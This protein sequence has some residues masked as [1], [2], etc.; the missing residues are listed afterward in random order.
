MKTHHTPGYWTQSKI[1]PTCVD[2]ATHCIVE[3]RVIDDDTD[4]AIAN[5]CLIAAAPNLLEALKSCLEALRGSAGP[6]EINNARAAAQLAI[7]N[8]LVEK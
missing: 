6:D 3:C 2:S 1:I 4:T 8:A 7:D 5:A